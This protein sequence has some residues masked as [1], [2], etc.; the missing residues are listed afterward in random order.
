MNH[1][2]SSWLLLIVLTIITVYLADFVD[3]R[4]V[5]IGSA[6]CIVVIKGQQIIDV[7]MELDKAPTFWRLLFL[8][9]IVFVPLIITAIYLML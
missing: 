8:S 2:I 9:Y 4:N 6:L 1:T 7:F 3:N 5:Y